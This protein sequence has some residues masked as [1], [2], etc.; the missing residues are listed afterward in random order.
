MKKCPKCGTEYDDNIKFC[1]ADGTELP[2]SDGSTKK[3]PSCNAE[4][5]AAAK[6]CNNCGKKFGSGLFKCVKCGCEYEKTVNFCNECGEKVADESDMP[7]ELPHN[8]VYVDGG[9]LWL[10]DDDKGDN[11]RHKV[12]LDS[13]YISK[14]QV[15]QQLWNSVMSYDNSE[16][17]GKN[18]PVDNVSWYDA[19]V[20]C[21]ELSK[22]DGL[23]PCYKIDKSHKDPN[24]EYEYDDLKWTVKCNFMAN[25][26]RLPTEAEWEYAARGGQESKGYK[27]SG[28]NEADDVAWYDDNSDDETHNVGE[29]NCNELGLYDMSGNVWEWCWDWYDDEINGGRNPTGPSSGSLRVQRGGSFYCIDL[30]AVDFRNHDCPDRRGRYGS[31]GFRLVCTAN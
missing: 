3:C 22:K 8:M 23:T 15:T 11:P 16:H 27:Y 17:I 2:C 20:F 25:G 12:T 5:P 21:N 4:N 13:F 10:G 1:Q 28:S 26:Y 9:S 29:K 18:R 31:S 19:V 24:N 30:C 14:Y 6:F 7:K